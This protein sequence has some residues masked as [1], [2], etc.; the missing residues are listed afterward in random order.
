MREVLLQVIDQLMN[1]LEF[2][3]QLQLPMRMAAR[4]MMQHIR[5][6]H[7]APQAILENEFRNMVY[8]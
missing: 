2:Q 7:Y 3:L 5:L 4:I 1:E 8:I 6:S